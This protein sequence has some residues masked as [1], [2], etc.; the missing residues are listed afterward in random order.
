MPQFPESLDPKGRRGDRR[1]E[2]EWQTISYR[3]VMMV[4]MIV[5]LLAGATLYFLYPEKVRG[6]FASVL[7]KATPAPSKPSVVQRQAQFIALEGNVRVKKSN[8]IQWIAASPNLTLEKG[9]VVQSSADGVAKISFADGTVYT[10]NPDTL[11]VVEENSGLSNSKTTNVAVQVTSGEVDL[12]TTKFEGESKVIFANAVARMGRDSRARVK[13]DPRS[14]TTEFTMAQGHS[15]V[16]RGTERV[17]LGSYEQVQFRG[18]SRMNRQRV[19]GPPVLLIP[20]HNAPVIARDPAKSE[21]NFSWTPV[22]TAKTYRLRISPSPIFTSVVYD[23][24]VNSATVKVTGLAEGTLYWAV[25]SLDEKNQES[26]ISDANKFTF[27]KQSPKDEILL[28]V[29]NFVLHGKVI[30]IIG[31]AE[32]G[33]RIMVNDE[34]VFAVLPDGTFKHFTQPVANQGANQ[35]TITAQNAKGQIATRRKTVYIQ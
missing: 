19:M 26:Q 9:D 1:V 27:L 8:S 14:Q 31:R 17:T 24:R 12:S 11:I 25:S 22:P 4:A 2:I 29:D 32:P 18:D 34:P 6:A 13:N 21:V 28:E 16:Q 7:K 35:I 30:E 3:S 23:K 20:A 33:A 10:V 15:E 5:V